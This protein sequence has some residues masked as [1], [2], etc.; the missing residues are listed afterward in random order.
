MLFNYNTEYRRKIGRVLREIFV[1]IKK[2]ARARTV[3]LKLARRD[4]MIVLCVKDD[5]HGFSAVEGSTGGNSFGLQSIAEDIKAIGGVISVESD[6]SQGTAIEIKFD[7][8]G[9]G[10][11]CLSEP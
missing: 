10:Q 8:P 7:F 4:G 2:H 3:S 1:N 6:P 5:G 11:R 9:E